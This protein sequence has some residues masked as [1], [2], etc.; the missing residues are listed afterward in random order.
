MA[1]LSINL[2]SDITELSEMFAV[3]DNPLYAYGDPVVNWNVWEYVCHRPLM[4]G[5]DH[6]LTSQSTS[7]PNDLL[8]EC[9]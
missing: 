6:T 2:F 7:C 8:C 9:V 1:S 5:S 3:R 4:H